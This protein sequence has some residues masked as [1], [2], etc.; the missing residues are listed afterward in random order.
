[1]GRLGGDRLGKKGT[2]GGKRRRLE[3]VGL[4]AWLWDGE[5][6]PWHC[7]PQ[8]CDSLPTQLSAPDREIRLQGPAPP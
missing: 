3:R 7:W 1:M 8:V 4:V 5:F 6:A 2:W